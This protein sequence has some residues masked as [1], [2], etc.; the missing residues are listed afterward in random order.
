MGDPPVQ[1]G[2]LIAGRYRL[3]SRIGEGGMGVVHE[4]TDEQLHRAVAIKFVASTAQYDPDRLARF[5]NEA[6]ALSALNHPHIVTI[7]EIGEVAGTPFIAMELV[8]GRTLRDRL[9]GGPLPA[10]EALDI[11]RQVARALS[12]AR[13][14][15]SPASGAPSR[16]FS[17]PRRP[18]CGAEPVDSDARLLRSERNG[19]RRH[20]RLHVAR[21]D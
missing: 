5:K 14:S 3:G 8:E 7:H 12:A 13:T 16:T 6:R 10:G 11:V 18:A 1:S 21:T 4:A 9:R 20:A 17:R 15:S 2:Q 19:R